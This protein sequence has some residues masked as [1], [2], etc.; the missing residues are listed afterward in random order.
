MAGETDD[1]QTASSR[2]PHGLFT[3][4][5][6]VIQKLKMRVAEYLQPLSAIV[7]KGYWKTFHP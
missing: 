5:R 4:Y 6:V 3:G 7:L 2:A 1:E